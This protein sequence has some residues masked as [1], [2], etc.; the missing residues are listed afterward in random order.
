[1]NFFAVTGL[2]PYT[3]L[4]IPVSGPLQTELQTIFEEQRNE[5]LEGIDSYVGFTPSYILESNQLFQIGDY[6][7]PAAL[8]NAM[9]AP[10]EVDEISNDQLAEIKS[11]VATEN[12]ENSFLFQTFERRR[13][14]R[15]GGM[16]IIL[17]DGTYRRMQ[18]SGLTLDS[19]LAAVH[20]NDGLYFRSF[21]T[22]RRFLP[23]TAY[24][25]EATDADIQ[26]FTNDPRITL[27]TE[28]AISANCDQRLRKQIAVV[29]K[30][31]IL[32]NYSPTDLATKAQKFGLA[33]ELSGNGN[34]QALVL[35][36]DKARLKQIL[37]FLEE[38]YFESS[39]SGHQF[40]TNSKLPLELA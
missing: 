13:V 24:F 25:E 21:Y 20:E 30:S 35:P 39:I 16:S 2:D 23:L 27:E 14:I 38:N 26:S 9:Q 40:E 6:Q 31:G 18:D 7:I 37:K 22:A 36:N 12:D 1:M 5:Y 29:Q 28:D 11:V 3:L 34:T 32:N 8:V 33:I 19:R 17:S 4:R 10:M 15:P